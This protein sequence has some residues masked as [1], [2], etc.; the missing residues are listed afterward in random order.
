MPTCLQC[1]SSSLYQEFHPPKTKVGRKRFMP[2]SEF[3][4]SE[5]FCYVLKRTNKNKNE[6]RKVFKKLENLLVAAHVMQILLMAFVID[7]KLHLI[8]LRKKQK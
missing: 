5:N 7:I 6:K 4:A 3:S 8:N 1:S 2:A